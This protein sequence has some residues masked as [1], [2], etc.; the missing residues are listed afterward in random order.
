MIELDGSQHYSP[1]GISR[2][3]ARTAA[4]EKYGV[5]VLRFSNTDIREN[6]RGV[7]EVINA[8]LVEE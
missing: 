7:C 1:E 4:I 5:R 3:A 6:L 8:A 2:D